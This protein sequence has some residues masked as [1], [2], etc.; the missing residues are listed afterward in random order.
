MQQNI[1]KNVKE[2]LA[3]PVARS[4]ARYANKQLKQIKTAETLPPAEDSNNSI[5]KNNHSTISSAIQ[6][7]SNSKLDVSLLT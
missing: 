6:T 1:S 2:I 3:I 4:K 7:A 5:T